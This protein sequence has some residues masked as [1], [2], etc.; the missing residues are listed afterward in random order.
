VGVFHTQYSDL[1]YQVST[2]SGAGF[3]TRNIIVDQDSTGVEWES[4]LLLGDSFRLHTS[5]GYISV[6][7][8][9]PVA[10]APLTPEWTASISPE[11]S[12]ALASGG[13]LLLR[14]DWSYRD[15]M[16]GEPTPDP[17][18]FT[19]IDSRS[20]LN[21]NVT[22]QSEDGGWTLGAY[23]RNVTDERYDQGRLNTGDYVLVMLSNDASEFGLRFTQNFGR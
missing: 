7:V 10:V 3:D 21:L 5:A 6:D 14:A 2:T 4:T 20:L 9:D 8:D 18:R 13:N 1:P 15:Q 17:A 16:Y 12:F 11:Y 19:S 23:G 22:Y